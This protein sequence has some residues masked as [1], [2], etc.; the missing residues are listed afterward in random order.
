MV[1]KADQ[2]KVEREFGKALTTLPEE[3]LD[4][5]DMRHS[6]KRKQDYRPREQAEGGR[7][8]RLSPLLYRL[9]VCT[10]CGCERE[11][12][13]YSRTFERLSTSYK[14]PEHYQMRGVGAGTKPVTALRAEQWRRAQARMKA[15]QEGASSA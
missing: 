7:R 2:A 11:D 4:C 10:R 6:W 9:L 8:S 1:S 5:R 3:F 13:I 12:V 15:D 14:Y